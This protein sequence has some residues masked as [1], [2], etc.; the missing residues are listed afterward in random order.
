MNSPRILV[1]GAGLIGQRHIAMLQARGW[2]AAIADPAPAA[3]GVAEAAAV[4]LFDDLEAA[5]DGVKPDGV[6]LASPNQLHVA[7]ALACV[8]RGIPV[9][10]EKPIADRVE[11][12]RRL[13][14]AARTA[15]VPILV[16]HHRRHNPLIAA[17]KAAIEAGRLGRI[18]AVN[19]LFW[20][21]KPDA[22][23]A[24]DWRRQE[25]AGPVFINLIHDL[26][27]LRHLCG[28]VAAVQ[29]V[30][31]SAVR[32]FAVEDTAAML[33]EFESGALGTVSISDCAVSPWSWEFAAGENPAYPKTDVPAYTIAGTHGALSVPD[34][35]LWHH[36]EERSWWAPI[37]REALPSAQRDPL[38]AQLDHFA[39]VIAGRA[40]PLVSGE[41]GLRTLQVLE[42]VKR[43]AREGRRVVLSGAA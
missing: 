4:P 8:A 6:L 43:A 14:D 27:L 9:L 7:Q 30:E 29:A 15:Q 23:F 13:V 33:L 10:V 42:A 22:Y 20:L 41:E 2:L 28:E 32:G 25:G 19:A 3:R 11:D 37:R 38:E 31:S 12:A 1:V 16:G 17:A 39:A 24:P 5:L 34:L 40:E 21:Y 35:G 26:D 18:V 36:P